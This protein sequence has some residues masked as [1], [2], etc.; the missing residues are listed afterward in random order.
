[1]EYTD[2]SEVRTAFIIRAMNQVTNEE[3]KLFTFSVPSD[4]PNGLLEYCIR[5]VLNALSNKIGRDKKRS[6]FSVTHVFR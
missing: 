6:C 3:K 1:L 4:L 5:T 2:V